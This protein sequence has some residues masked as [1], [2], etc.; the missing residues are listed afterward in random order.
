MKKIRG[1]RRGVVSS[2]PAKN[3]HKDEQDRQDISEEYGYAE[4]H[5]RAERAC[6]FDKIITLSF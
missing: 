5:S 2:P 1:I 6:V 4:T 3:I